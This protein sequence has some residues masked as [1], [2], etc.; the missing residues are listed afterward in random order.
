MFLSSLFA[1]YKDKKLRQNLIWAVAELF[2]NNLI[3]GNVIIL[4]KKKRY[5]GYKQKLRSG[6]I[7]VWVSWDYLFSLTKYLD[8]FNTSFHFFCKAKR[9]HSRLCTGESFNYWWEHYIRV[10]LVMLNKIWALPATCIC[11]WCYE[12]TGRRKK[13]STGF[14]F[15]MIRISSVNEMDMIITSCIT[16]AEPLL[17][18]YWETQVLGYHS[19][20]TLWWKEWIHLK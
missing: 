5:K 2:W 7:I 19:L 14:R 8:L 10:I 12:E 17:T 20:E 18:L 16:T 11:F 3:Y 4:Q 13:N 6:F 15:R 1:C 9:Y